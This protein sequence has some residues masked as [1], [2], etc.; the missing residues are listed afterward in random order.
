MPLGKCRAMTST[1]SSLTADIPATK[2]S[3]TEIQAQEGTAWSET[4]VT[5]EDSLMAKRELH[6]LKRNNTTIMLDAVCPC[7]LSMQNY[8]SLIKKKKDI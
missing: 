4:R 2:L 5:R 8:H 3:N 1:D 7:D 6:F